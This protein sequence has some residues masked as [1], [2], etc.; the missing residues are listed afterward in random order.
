MSSIDRNNICAFCTLCGQDELY[1][2]ERNS[3]AYKVCTNG[4]GTALLP[5]LLRI[6][7]E[8][9]SAVARDDLVG[10]AL[11]HVAEL[12]LLFAERLDGGKELFV[13]LIRAERVFLAVA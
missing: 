5:S 9:L 2:N 3:R 4:K 13:R 10:L 1:E 12:D 7:G 8:G 6:W 11:L